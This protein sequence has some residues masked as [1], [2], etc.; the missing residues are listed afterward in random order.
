MAQ[1]CAKDSSLSV[2]WKQKNTTKGSA[3]RRQTVAAGCGTGACPTQM[4]TGRHSPAM[5][6]VAF[7]AS[8]AYSRLAY[9]TGKPHH[10]TT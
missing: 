10:K 6:W 7:G 8:A 9:L 3:C 2:Q 4:A 1:G 5:G